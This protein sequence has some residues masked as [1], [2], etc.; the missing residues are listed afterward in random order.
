MANTKVSNPIIVATN[1]DP[2]P[3]NV[4]SLPSN[5]TLG[6]YTWRC[7]GQK[8]TGATSTITFSVTGTAASPR[9]VAGTDNYVAAT[10]QVKAATTNYVQVTANFFP[11]SNSLNWTIWI[12][13]GTSNYVK[14]TRGNGGGTGKK[15]AAK[16]G[17]MVVAKPVVK[18]APA[19]NATKTAKKA[20]TKAA[21]KTAKKKVAA[22]P[23][24]KRGK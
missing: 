7:V 21:P 15:G 9:I 14:F 20:A 5:G 11:N 10:C 17:A 6:S 3:T 2:A 23:A 12:G 19:K 24:K 4:S 13:T 22:K 1:S 18:K 8:N 16:A